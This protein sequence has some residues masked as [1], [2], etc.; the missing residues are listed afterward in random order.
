MSYCRWNKNL[1]R[2]SHET[3]ASRLSAGWELMASTVLQRRT[4]VD[5]IKKRERGR[6][7]LCRYGK[8]EGLPSPT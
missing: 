2:V 5:K 7:V 3:G 8:G 6:V 1:C 4:G